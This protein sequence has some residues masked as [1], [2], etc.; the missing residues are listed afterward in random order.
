MVDLA[1]RAREHAILGLEVSVLETLLPADDPN[2]TKTS[3]CAID[4]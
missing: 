2:T 1:E 3:R 4:W